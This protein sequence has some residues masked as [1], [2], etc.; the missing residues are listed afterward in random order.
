MSES[1]QDYSPIKQ[2]VIA[3]VTIFVYTC[4]KQ[5]ACDNRNSKLC[6]SVRQFVST[7]YGKV[8]FSA[9]VTAVSAKPYITIVL[10]I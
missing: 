5:G 4:L 2:M 6:W 1:F 7:I 9:A 3:S 8:C 10:G